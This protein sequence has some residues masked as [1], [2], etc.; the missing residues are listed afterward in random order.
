M[1]PQSTYFLRVIG[2]NQTTPTAGATADI[3]SVIDETDAAFAGSPFAM[4]DMGV[5]M[6]APYTYE[7]LTPGHTYYLYGPSMQSD[8]PAPSMPTTW[9]GQLASTSS[10]RVGTTLA[11]ASANTTTPQPYLT[12]GPYDLLP[13][14]DPI[15]GV[16]EFWGVFVPVAGQP[17]WAT[18]VNSVPS[19]HGYIVQ[20]TSQPGWMT[21][22]E[23][24]VSVKLEQ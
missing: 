6:T 3:E 11:G 10:H 23:G 14:F 16:V 18:M 7:R 4:P 17:N 9:Q 24:A 5:Q 2:W 20:A 8:N 19:V 22:D 12:G 13:V 15:S 1:V 21:M